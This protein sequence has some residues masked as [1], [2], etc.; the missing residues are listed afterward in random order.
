MQYIQVKQYAQVHLTDVQQIIP[1]ADLFY[2]HVGTSVKQDHIFIISK[3]D[4]QGVY[5]EVYQN[6]N[7]TLVQC[8]KLLLPFLF[9]LAQQTCFI[10]VPQY[11]K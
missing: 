10:Y 9:Q 6:E 11:G 2:E 4:H 5:V 7:R 3:K 1:C 8:K